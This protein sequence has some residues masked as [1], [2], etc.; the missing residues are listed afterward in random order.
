MNKIYFFKTFM[1]FGFMFSDTELILRKV[2]GMGYWRLI[3][4]YFGPVNVFTVN[5]CITCTKTT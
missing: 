4:I 5:A 1:P 3:Y 2:I